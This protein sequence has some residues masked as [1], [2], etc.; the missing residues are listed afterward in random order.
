[1]EFFPHVHSVWL[2]LV[3]KRFEDDQ[4]DSYILNPLSRINANSWE[5]LMAQVTS[6]AE[7][8][9][10]LAVV[11]LGVL[12]AAAAV[13]TFLLQKLIRELG[14]A[15]EDL[16]TVRRSVGRILQDLA[17]LTGTAGITL[18]KGRDAVS[19]LCDT[20]ETVRAV[21]SDAKSIIKKMVAEMGNPVAE[22]DTKGEESRRC[23]DSVGR[24]PSP[25]ANSGERAT[26]GP[27]ASAA[28]GAEEEG[29]L[30]YERPG[31]G[32]G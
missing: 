31:Q 24:D 9:L 4:K 7:F 1:M 14:R 29:L 27:S 15:Y 11:F 2:V 21:V 17:A 16:D 6:P 19:A 3:E 10:F 22:S 23:D 12:A 20:V 8:L 26:E 18:N 13:Q 32:D 5:T 28:G 25:D 30:V